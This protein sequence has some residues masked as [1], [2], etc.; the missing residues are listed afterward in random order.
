PVGF[1]LS[2]VR[3][4]L[5]GLS[6]HQTGKYRSAPKF[7]VTSG[8]GFGKTSTLHALA[9]EW[10]K[11]NGHVVYAPAA[12]LQV[13]SFASASGLV[14][15]LLNFLIPEDS[16]ISPLAHHVIRDAFRQTMARSKDWLVLIDGLDESPFAFNANS[17]AALW[18]SM[19]DLGTPIVL[20]ARD[21]LV[22]A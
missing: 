22:E 1:V 16:N 19:R 18:G 10:I 7:L 12:L 13:V 21:E 2:F 6:E 14:N 3:E 5:D 8:F 15:A 17:L 9:R 4:F 11:S 20:S